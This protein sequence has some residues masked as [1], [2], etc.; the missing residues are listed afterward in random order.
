MLSSVSPSSASGMYSTAILVCS[1]EQSNPPSHPQ[2][3]VH[4]SMAREH[5]HRADQVPQTC[6]REAVSVST[7]Y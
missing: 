5:E 4:G 6:W 3:S 1:L 2:N 7:F